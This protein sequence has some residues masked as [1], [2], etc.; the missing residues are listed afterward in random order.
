MAGESHNPQE[1]QEKLY[2]TLSPNNK[3]VDQRSGFLDLALD[4]AGG[5][6]LTEE[7]ASISNESALTLD[8]LDQPPGDFL[9]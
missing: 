2:L 9:I 7:D 4:V 5:T 1:E 6:A 3:I 8:G